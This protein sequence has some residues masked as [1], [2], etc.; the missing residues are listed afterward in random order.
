M[1]RWR[2]GGEDEGDGREERPEMELVV[3]D[4]KRE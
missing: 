4:Y 2:R 1:R 3:S